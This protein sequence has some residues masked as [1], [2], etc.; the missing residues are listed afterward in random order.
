M[1]ASKYSK[2][3]EC[4]AQAKNVKQPFKSVSR[5][6][7]LLELIHTDICDNKDHLTRGEKRYFITFIDDY[8]KYTYVYLLKTKDEAFEKFKNFKEEVEN[9]LGKRI[10]RIRSDRG[11]EYYLNDY[12]KFCEKHGIV[13]EE[14]APNSPS[15]NGVAE[16]KNRTLLEMVSAMLIHSKLPMNFLGEA[17]FTAC[18][19]TNRIL[20][21]N[22]DKT[23]YEM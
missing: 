3:C 19:I 4:Y 14:S 2:N 17:L 22:Q 1:N 18:Y 15:Q 9:T 13:R 10:Q 16:R 20:H 5:N 8:S 6:T 11:G 21:K 23:P 12:I 7:T